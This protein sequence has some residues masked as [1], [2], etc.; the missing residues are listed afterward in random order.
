MLDVI[1]S[2]EK[3]RSASLPA[4]QVESAG[5]YLPTCAGCIA[6]ELG[7]CPGY[8]VKQQSGVR[9]VSQTFPARR[10]I[11]HQR[12]LADVVPVICSGWAATS[13]PTPHGKRQVVAFLI[14]GDTASINYLFEACGG[15]A[16]E[17]V[18]PVTCRKFRRAD[19]QAA[20]IRHPAFLSIIGKA[21]ADERESRDQLNFDLSR[22]SAE[23][24]I[25]H[26]ILGIYA[27]LKR[28][29][30]AKDGA[31]E[32]P[33]RQQQL[34]DALG[35]TAVHVCK[36]ISRLRSARIIEL[37]GRKLKILDPKVLALLAEQ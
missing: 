25:T 24:R 16:I 22:R 27:R 35:L 8:G 5:P 4:T 19:L 11:L 10:T 2:V 21:L 33:L 37:Q 6:R 20:A 30:L 23:S 12:E 14:A 13:L 29:G 28:R 3:S 1:E 18:S 7:G 32:F 34:A 31:F 9:S 26:L 15:R 17:A 36:I